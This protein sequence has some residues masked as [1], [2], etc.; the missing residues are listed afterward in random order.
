MVNEISEPWSY[1]I[2]N[3]RL[4]MRYF[5]EMIYC[6]FVGLSEKSKHFSN[7]SNMWANAEYFWTRGIELQRNLL[8][9][10]MGH[11]LFWNPNFKN[12]GIFRKS[13]IIFITFYLIVNDFLNHSEIHSIL[14]WRETRAISCL[15]SLIT[16]HFLLPDRITF[17]NV[18]VV[19][20][21][22]RDLNYSYTSHKQNQP[23]R[24]SFKIFA[25]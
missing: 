2:S 20:L 15:S 25:V 8:L 21:V 18:D 4:E 11:R 23:S 9:S 17:D 6:D 22:E 5:T 24:V 7:L 16:N 1:I 12:N 19:C 13:I 10:R 14:C 3:L